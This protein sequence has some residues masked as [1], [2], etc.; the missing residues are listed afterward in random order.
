MVVLAMGFLGPEKSILKELEL[1]TD[2][3]SNIKTLGGKFASSVPRV[4]AAGGESPN[5]H[6][7][8]KFYPSPSRSLNLLALDRELFSHPPSRPNNEH[9]RCYSRANAM[10]NNPVPLLL[11]H[12]I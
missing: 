10:R 5:I 8:G 9:C 7:L 4:Y 2:P 6:F 3:R 1:E 11:Q 12:E